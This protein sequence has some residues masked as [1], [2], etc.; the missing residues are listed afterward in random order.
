MSHVTQNSI[1]MLIVIWGKSTVY[2]HTQEAISLF[3]MTMFGPEKEN[4]VI[5]NIVMHLA[6]TMRKQLFPIT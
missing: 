3:T 6:Q 5:I 1:V 4:T 2:I